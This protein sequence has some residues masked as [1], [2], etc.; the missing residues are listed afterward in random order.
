[1][2]THTNS[3]EKPKVHVE[4]LVPTLLQAVTYLTDPERKYRLEV[5]RHPTVST[6]YRITIPVQGH[7]KQAVLLEL[8][9]NI[10]WGHW[11]VEG[12]P[13]GGTG[14]THWVHLLASAD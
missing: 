6:A 14:T 4:G 2:K 13:P 5:S 9:F 11:Y 3:Q 1:M 7:A 12:S 10:D 8:L